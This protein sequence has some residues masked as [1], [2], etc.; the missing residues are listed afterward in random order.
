MSKLIIENKIENLER[1]LDFVEQFALS[2]KLEDDTTFDIKLA[3]DEAVSNIVRHGYN[4]NERHFIEIVLK[5]SDDEIN[6]TVIDDAKE[7]NMLDFTVVNIDQP[8]EERKPGGLGI[9]LIKE[10]MDEIKWQRNEGKNI[11]S[12]TKKILKQ[13]NK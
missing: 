11:L 9:F 10:T 7:F 1:V 2:I 12:L 13:E 4:D 5:Q 8:I 3:V 6:I